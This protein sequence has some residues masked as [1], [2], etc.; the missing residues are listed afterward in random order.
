LLSFDDGVI[1]DVEVEAE[2]KVNKAGGQTVE[3]IPLS[4]GVKPTPAD[5]RVMTKYMTI[6][7]K[8][9]VLGT[10]ALQ[11]AM[12]C[13]VMVPTGGESDSLRIAEMELKEKKIPIIIRR[14]MPNGS[15]EDWA[16]D[17]LIVPG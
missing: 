17:E 2:V 16:V 13:P 14:F 9:R 3:I 12:N 10:R 5:K 15:F 11:I 7:E 6:Y 8:A 1:E 4:A